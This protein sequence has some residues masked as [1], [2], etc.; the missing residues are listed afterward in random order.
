MV[1]NGQVN[2]GWQWHVPW[3]EPAVLHPYSRSNLIELIS[4]T[5]A[6]NKQRFVVQD[7]PE[8]TRSF[9]TQTIFACTLYYADI[10]ILFLMNF[11]GCQ[12]LIDFLQEPPF[13]HYKS[14][15][16]IM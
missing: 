5:I 1:D 13:N 8:F 7:R 14:N 10:H 6:L 11:Q 15:V 4:R 2:V 12:I 3:L 9:S 16:Y